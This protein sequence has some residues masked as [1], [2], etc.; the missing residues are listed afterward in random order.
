[1]LCLF[2][3][4]TAGSGCFFISVEGSEAAP[5]PCS[6]ELLRRSLV[7]FLSMAEMIGDLE[8]GAEENSN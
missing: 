5:T 6:R 8:E 7:A 2:L 4:L 1:M 3:F